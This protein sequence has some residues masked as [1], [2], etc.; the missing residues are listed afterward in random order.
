MA[1]YN[2]FVVCNSRTG[3]TILVTSSA[4]KARNELRLGRRIEVWN[5]NRQEHKIIWRNRERIKPYIQAERD[6]IGRRQL[7]AE[8]KNKARK[9]IRA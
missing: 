1:K 8:M 2:T 5:G 6:Y 3:K 7:A 9:I 4:R